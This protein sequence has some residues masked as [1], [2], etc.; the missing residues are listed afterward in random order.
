MS[1]PYEST[2]TDDGA[3]LSLTFLEFCAMV[4]RDDPSILPDSGEPLRIDPLSENEDMELADALLENTNVT[5]LELGTEKYTKSSAEA[6]AKY[7][8]TSKCLQ[9]I[10][11]KGESRSHCPNSLGTFGDNS[12]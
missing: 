7:L 3:P 8:R 5:Y 1:D 2:S 4:R 9:R 10:H 12:C 11:W 6:M